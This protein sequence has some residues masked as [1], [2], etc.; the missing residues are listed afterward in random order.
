MAS[1]SDSD[2]EKDAASGSD[3]DR[4]EDAASGYGSGS[5]SDREE[6]AASGSGSKSQRGPT[7]KA[8]ANKKIVVTYNKRGVPTGPGAKKYLLLRDWWQDLWFS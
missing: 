8:K 4:E 1:G 6:D 5:D 7:I 2:R 3:S